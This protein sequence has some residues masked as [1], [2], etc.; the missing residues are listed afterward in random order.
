MAINNTLRARLEVL[1]G[2]ELI[3]LFDKVGDSAKKG[4]DKVDKEAEKATREVKRLERELKSL[5]RIS[6]DIRA[7]IKIDKD[8]T[9][10][11]HE[12]AALDL[13][14]DID[15]RASKM[16]RALEALDDV[17]A[18]TRG[19]G[20]RILGTT[21]DRDLLTV[22]ET[23]RA[24]DE[25]VGDGRRN[26]LFG[27]IVP[28]ADLDRILAASERLRTENDEFFKGLG[29]RMEAADQAEKDRAERE[30]QRTERASARDPSSPESEAKRHAAEEARAKREEEREKRIQ[31]AQNRRAEQASRD[32]K[33]D[34]DYRDYMARERAR[35]DDEIKR[36]REKFRQ[37]TEDNRKRLQRDFDAQVARLNAER[38]GFNDQMSRQR[39]SHRDELSR[40]RQNHAAEIGR[41]HSQHQAEISRLNVAHQDQLRRDRADYLRQLGTERTRMHAQIGRERAR[42]TTDLANERANHAAL[43]GRERAAFHST[44][45][46]ERAAASRALL[47][48]QA[49]NRARLAS[50]RAAHARNIAS[51][52][53]AF[54]STMATER[55]AFAAAAQ[56]DRDRIQALTGD[57]DALRQAMRGV[58]TAG[59]AFRHGAPRMGRAARG[60]GRLF[61]DAARDVSRFGGALKQLEFAIGNTALRAGIGGILGV[62]GAGLA[63]LGGAAVLGGISAIG[64]IASWNAQQLQNAAKSVGQSLDA[65]T[66][67]K[68]VAGSSGINFDDYLSGAAALR[69][70]M[71][72]IKERKPDAAVAANLFR[73]YRIP[74]MDSTGKDFSSQYVILRHIA[75][76]LKQ[77]PNDNIRIEFLTN[78]GGQ[79]LAKLLP[80]LQDGAAGIDKQAQRAFDLGVVLTDAQVASFEKLWASV[81]DMWQ[82][83]I[84]LSYKLAAEIMPTLLPVLEAINTWALSN[85]D[86]I[87]GGLVK[88]FDY[89]I[90]VTKDFWALWVDRENVFKKGFGDGIQTRWAVTFV[91][92]TAVIIRALKRVWTAIE[93][94]YKFA[95]P[96]LEKLAEKFGMSGPLEVALTFLVGQLLGISALFVGMAR[97]ASTA[98]TFVA[99][100]LKNTLMPI[101]RTVLGA[102]AG[103]IGWPLLLAIGI[104][105]VIAYWDDIGKLFEAAWA[106]FKQTFPTTATWMEQTFGEALKS[107]KSF[108]SDMVADFHEK[109]PELSAFFGRLREAIDDISSTLKNLDWGLLFSSISDVG[110]KALHSLLSLLEKI[111]PLLSKVVMGLAYMA[112]DFIKG[113]SDI[114]IGVNALFDVAIAAGTAQGELLEEQAMFKK[115]P[116]A[117]GTWRAQLGA[118]NTAIE[119]YVATSGT[120]LDKSYLAKMIEVSSISSPQSSSLTLPAAAAPAMQTPVNVNLQ[121]GDTIYMVSP[122]SN[123]A[124]RLGAFSRSQ[125]T[126]GPSWQR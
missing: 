124:E 112:S 36:S 122:E 102:V 54:A 74:F 90:Q 29:D 116:K 118:G 48:E 33:R 1:G 73:Q 107:V 7:K 9:P 61:S 93:T 60:M 77:M 5:E 97:V 20:V 2:K 114:V 72:D 13:A 32:A 28:D 76:V 65:F 16:R 39:Q 8:R 66:A 64:I 98:V 75:D 41:L 19:D 120:D 35:L 67:M 11:V 69:Q 71:M 21:G 85:Q 121:N 81:Y 43:I 27:D 63:A 105:L 108:T 83:I 44:M 58:N 24:L 109:Y 25:L 111:S 37:E 88:T 22:R 15:R 3:D 23:T 82:I 30:R 46:S 51:E 96:L 14:N 126:T 56:Q 125:P 95:T 92:A 80:M 84:G 119:K 49:G 57:V 59:G 40:A 110:M 86:A 103:I 78:L 100:I 45:A 87:T 62:L 70:R 34:Q 79:D 91:Y 104:G 113:V 6:R 99:N 68:Y 117:W 53:A 89:L 123:V 52:R 10:S 38:Q 18:M 50:E 26:G 4:F 42:F 94:G 115:D 17:A 47:G 106:K 12:K 101:V 55:A 31:D